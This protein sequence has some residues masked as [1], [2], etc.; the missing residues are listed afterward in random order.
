MA[1]PRRSASL[2]ILLLL[3]ASST[4]TSSPVRQG[5]QEQGEDTVQAPP[6][7]NTKTDHHSDGAIYVRLDDVTE[8]LGEMD[9]RVVVVPGYSQGAGVSTDEDRGEQNGRVAA[10]GQPH[11]VREGWGT[12]AVKAVLGEV[13]S[14]RARLTRIWAEVRGDGWEEEGEGGGEVDVEG[15]GQGDL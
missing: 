11:G 6:L 2:F 12:H 14:W 9:E 1:P 7:L 4:A 15:R 3:A 8:S 5:T 10:D 13:S